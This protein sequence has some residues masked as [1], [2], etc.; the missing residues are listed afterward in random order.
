MRFDREERI[1][2]SLD[3]GVHFDLEGSATSTGGGACSKQWSV[4][5][6][7]QLPIDAVL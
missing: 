5:W 3:K 1:I 7:K 4:E 2:L 6:S